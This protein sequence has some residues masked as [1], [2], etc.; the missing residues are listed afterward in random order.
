MSMM[1]RVRLV[2][3]LRTVEEAEIS[4]RSAKAS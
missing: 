2:R 3:I 4:P 1:V